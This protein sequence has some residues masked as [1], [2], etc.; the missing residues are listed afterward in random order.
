MGAVP[1]EYYTYDDY[2]QWEGDWELID[3]IPYAMAPSP[4]KTHQNLAYELFFRIREQLEEKDCQ[5]C[6]VLGEFDYKISN[7]T[8]LRPDIVFTCHE[9]HERYLTKA[10]QI[11]F[12]VISP[13]SAKRDEIY[14]FSLY[15]KEKVKYYVLVYPDDLKAKIYKLKDGKYDKEGDFT[16]EVYDFKDSECEIKLDFKK[17]FKRFR[18]RKN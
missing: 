6:E 5:D 11:I 17:V 12:E 13:S 3:G 8:I 14:K 9:T 15:E 1:I 10:P 18:D 16:Q 2:I 4:M 7:N